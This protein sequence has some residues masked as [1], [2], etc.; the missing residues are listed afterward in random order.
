V[1]RHNIQN[2]IHLFLYNSQA[3]CRRTALQAMWVL[4]IG[5]LL[6]FASCARPGAPTGGL[7][8]S[9]PPKIDSAAST[10]NMLTRFDRKTIVL[11]F[12]EWVTLSE[13]NTQIIVSPPLKTK[14]VPEVVLKGK[15]V[16]VK[17]PEEEQLRPNTTYTINFGNSVKD[18]HEGNPAKD[19]RFVFSTGDHIDSLT[20]MG[21]V[22]K[23]F[24]AEP[25]ENA[26]IM[27]YENLSDS[28][29]VKEKPYYYTRS[30]KEGAFQIS[31]V[32]SGSFK[33]IAIEDKDQNLLWNGNDELI[34][35]LDAPLLR[36]DTFLGIPVTLRMH[37]N[38]PSRVR[39]GEKT[40]LQYGQIRLQ[41]NAPPDSVVFSTLPTDKAR[42][43]IE[44]N[45]D[46]VLVWYDLRDTTPIKLLAGRDTVTVRNFSKADFMKQHQMAWAGESTASRSARSKF[47]TTSTPASVQTL[48]QNPARDANLAFSFPVSAY[49]TA[50]WVLRVDSQIIYQLRVHKDTLKPRNLTFSANWLPEKTHELLLLPGAITDF[51]G[52][53]NTDTLRRKFTAIGE[54]QL[55]DL[56]L[57]VEDLI[58]GRHYLLE[59]LSGNKVEETRAFKAESS[60][61]KLIF[62]KLI[63]STYTAELTEDGNANARRDAGDYFKN[64]LPERIFKKELTA[65]RPGWELEASMKAGEKQ[66][67]KKTDKK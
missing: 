19:L 56:T 66:D 38:Q 9:T 31:N 52:K 6:L 7:K 53:S 23:A 51:W 20:V 61:K 65:L 22:V 57:T 10:P 12:D 15:T 60:S 50:R 33:I 25:I 44:K 58:P 48:I 36:N 63:S 42:L 46:S 8:D 43:L 2:M 54:K 11:K 39:L 47:Q 32:R 21:K 5:H 30:D 28:V 14:R 18:L 16:T 67:E 49:D 3:D 37:K 29:P 55:G 62:N 64:R 4:V 41:Y 40:N 1:I 24:G 34:G 35:F 26:A 27:L 59:L 45:M 17:I 13:Q